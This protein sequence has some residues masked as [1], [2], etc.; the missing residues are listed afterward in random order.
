MFDIAIPK[1]YFNRQI[2]R[3]CYKRLNLTVCY[4]LTDEELIV[5]DT[6]EL[7][8]KGTNMQTTSTAVF[9]PEGSVSYSGTA[10]DLKQKVFRLIVTNYLR[11]TPLQSGEELNKFKE[12]MKEMNVIITGISRG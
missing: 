2:V 7:K 10:Y 11:T 8:P 5:V 3:W 12:Y 9:L 1:K 4:I 6:E